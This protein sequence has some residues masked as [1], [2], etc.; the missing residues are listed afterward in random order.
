VYC[1]PWS[2]EAAQRLFDLRDNNNDNTIQ[3]I[4]R[5]DSQGKSVQVKPQITVQD[6]FDLFVNS[7]F[8]YLYHGNYLTKE[9]K[10]M[11]IRQAQEE[12]LLQSQSNDD[13]AASILAQESLSQ[14]D[15]MQSY[16]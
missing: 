3:L 6:T 12:G 16:G 7:D 15:K 2:K 9:E 13:T 10:L 4:V 8:T 11:S 5:D 1:L 14:A